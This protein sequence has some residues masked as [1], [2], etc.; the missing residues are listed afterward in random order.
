M[1][2]DVEENQEDVSATGFVAER[3]G[4]GGGLAGARWVLGR[5]R[6]DELEVD[7]WPSQAEI[8]RPEVWVLI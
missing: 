1:L 5:R 2:C 6:R 7:V 8:E 4:R 3:R